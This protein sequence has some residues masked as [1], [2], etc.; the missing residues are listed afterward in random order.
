[1]SRKGAGLSSQAEVTGLQVRGKESMQDE[2]A[3]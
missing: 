3:A 2:E 1:L